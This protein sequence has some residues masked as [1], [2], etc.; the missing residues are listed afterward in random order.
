MV[1]NL[2]LIYFLFYAEEVTVLVFC[3]LSNR[4]IEIKLMTTQW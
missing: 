2:Q 4:S 3:I 1:Y